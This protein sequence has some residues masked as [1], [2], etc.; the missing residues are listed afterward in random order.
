MDPYAG[1]GEVFMDKDRF[2]LSGVMHGEAIEFT[3]TTHEIGAFPITPGEHFDIYY[4]GKL[5]YVY[6]EPDPRTTVKWVCYLDK[7]NS[8]RRAKSAASN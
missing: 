5:I 1:D 2:T 8:D 3:K 4:K 7:L 6:P